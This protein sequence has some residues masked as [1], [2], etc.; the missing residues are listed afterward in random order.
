MSPGL[1]E[2]VRRTQSSHHHDSPGL[3]GS[4]QRR[5]GQLSAAARTSARFHGSAHRGYAHG[6]RHDQL[7]MRISTADLCQIG[8]F[9]TDQSPF[10]VPSSGASSLEAHQAFASAQSPQRPTIPKCLG[11]I[12]NPSLAW[13]ASAR[14]WNIV[15][16]ASI[17]F[18]Q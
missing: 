9:S 14:P 7:G 6:L 5:G 16:G 4:D 11:S 13:A 1:P 12:E 3:C 15:W 18:P 10:T 2:R 17:I 8:T